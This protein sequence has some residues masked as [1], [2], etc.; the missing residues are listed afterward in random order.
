VLL[1]RTGFVRLACTHGYHLVPSYAFGQNELYTVNQ[2]LLAGFRSWL[3]RKF[4]V[5]SR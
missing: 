2:S 3:Q 4:Q 1:G 5:S